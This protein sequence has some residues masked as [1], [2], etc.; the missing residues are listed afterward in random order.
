MADPAKKHKGSTEV[1][2]FDDLFPQLVDDISKYFLNSEG[3][4]SSAAWFREVGDCR[5]SPYIAHIV[6]RIVSF[7]Q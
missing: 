5:T 6:K 7:R 4:E 3:L 1:E 2:L